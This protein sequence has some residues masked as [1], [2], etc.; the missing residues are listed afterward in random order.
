MVREKVPLEQESRETSNFK[1]FF[2]FCSPLSKEHVK[3]TWKSHQW[4]FYFFKEVSKLT[5]DG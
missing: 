3:C 2:K 5:V 1:M 4:N